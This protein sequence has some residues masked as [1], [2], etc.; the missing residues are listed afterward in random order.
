VENAFESLD[1]ACEIY[2]RRHKLAKAVYRARERIRTNLFAAKKK[3][4]TQAQYNIARYIIFQ[5]RT[6]QKMM[7]IIGM[8][9]LEVS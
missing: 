5:F 3:N 2:R 8:K 6:R 4:K 1:R 7:Y 9:F